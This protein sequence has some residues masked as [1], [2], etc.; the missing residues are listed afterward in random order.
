[1]QTAFGLM[2]SGASV[3]HHRA[4]TKLA[5][6]PVDVI[7]QYPV[8]PHARINSA[9]VFANYCA[10]GAKFRAYNGSQVDVFLATNRQDTST[11]TVFM[12]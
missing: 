9:P 5:L 6:R 12:S 8:S 7:F 11:Q 10:V 2:P 3:P 1:M 4:E